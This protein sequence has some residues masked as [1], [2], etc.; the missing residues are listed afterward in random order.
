MPAVKP[1]PRKSTKGSTPVLSTAPTPVTAMPATH[2]CT[3]RWVLVS[4]LLPAVRG[5]HR[6]SA[7]PVLWMCIP[8]QPNLVTGIYRSPVSSCQCSWVQHTCELIHGLHSQSAVASSQRVHVPE[9]LPSAPS[10]VWVLPSP[11]CPDGKWT[12]PQQEMLRVRGDVPVC[13]LG[14]WVMRHRLWTVAAGRAL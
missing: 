1:R 2:L 11:R 5:D 7:G 8:A 9:A 6:R 13:E 4:P 14:A 10:A 3:L 12:E